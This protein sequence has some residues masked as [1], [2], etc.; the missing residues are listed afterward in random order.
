MDKKEYLALDIYSKSELQDALSFAPRLGWKLHSVQDVYSRSD[1][2][3]FS[4]S[5]KDRRSFSTNSLS[6][7]TFD[8]YVHGKVPGSLKES[9]TETHETSYSKVIFE[10]DNYKRGRETLITENNWVNLVK[11]EN[12]IFEIGNDADYAFV[13]DEK[14][15]G[16]SALIV[17]LIFLSFALVF[18]VFYLVFK[19]SEMELTG[20][21]LLMSNIFFFG[22]LGT[23]ALGLLFFLPSFFAIIGGAH[24]VHKAKK[25]REKW[26]KD[27][28]NVVTIKHDFERMYIQGKKPRLNRRWYKTMCRRYGFSFYKIRYK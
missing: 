18:W 5:K 6:G 22:A 20:N 21:L 17:S 19:L 11:L 2:A 26:A 8:E 24:S 16:N 4:L 28:E 9:R 13:S 15:R 12:K 23:S 14:K 7:L 10:R 25:N 3:H 27:Y 1:A